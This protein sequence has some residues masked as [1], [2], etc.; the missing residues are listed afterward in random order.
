MDAVAALTFDLEH[1]V[2]NTYP[3]LS[4]LT[5]DLRRVRKPPSPYLVNSLRPATRNLPGQHALPDTAP[6]RIP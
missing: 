1:S 5:F 3:P 6:L 2:P 4:L